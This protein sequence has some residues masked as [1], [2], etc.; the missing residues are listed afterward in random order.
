MFIIDH[1]RSQNKTKQNVMGY[2]GILQSQTWLAGE[3]PIWF[4]HSELEDHLFLW[5][6][7]SSSQTATN[8]QRVPL[9][10][11][12]PGHESCDVF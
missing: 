5:A 11:G 9:S 6:M 8:H 7:A 3:S 12:S 4:D 1:H 10:S 2:P